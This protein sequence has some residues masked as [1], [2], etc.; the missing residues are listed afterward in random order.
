MGNKEW[1]SDIRQ[2][3]FIFWLL[4]NFIYTT[5]VGSKIRNI[6]IVDSVGSWHNCLLNMLEDNT[7]TSIGLSGRKSNITP[8][9]FEYLIPNALLIQYGL[10][11]LD[12]SLFISTF[13][14]IL[15]TMFWNFKTVRRKSL[16]RRFQIR[17]ESLRTYISKIS[18]PVWFS[19]QFT[20][21]AKSEIDLLL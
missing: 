2:R 9:L 16:L 1:S 3:M 18:S 13:V 15:S 7:S 4:F 5:P 20:N 12:V 21:V 14:R 8:I 6:F 19:L 11:F 10:K 17:Y